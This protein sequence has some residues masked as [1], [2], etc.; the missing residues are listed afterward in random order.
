MCGRLNVTDH[1]ALID[2]LDVLGVAHDVIRSPSQGLLRFSR[3][4][5]A[6]EAVTL[7]RQQAGAS[8]LAVAT[9]WLLLEPTADG[10][11]PSPYTSFNTRSD[12]LAVRGSAGFQAFQSQRC[13][14]PVSGFGETEGTAKAARY[15]DFFADQALPLGGLYRRW[16]HQVTGEE[17][18]S[19][20]VITL[21][22]HPTLLPFHSKAMPLILPR[23]ACQRWLDP[24]TPLD[25]LMP[26]LIPRLPV[27]LRAQP[28]DKPSRYQPIGQLKWLDADAEHGT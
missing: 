15:T 11:K 9:W 21:A 28:I 17:R 24:T 6:T 14:I 18:L 23:D 27:A 16:V 4:I 10:F 22:P 2:L 26:L 13:I 19:C 7:V 8:Q 3:F 12:K 20:S 5:R 1:Q 25:H